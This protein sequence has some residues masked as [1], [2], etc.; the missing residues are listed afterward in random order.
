MSKVS[1]CIPTYNQTK[2]LKKCLQ[3]VCEQN[4]KDFEVIISDDSTTDEVKVYIDA[5][6]IIQPLFY[7]RN[8][9]SLGSPQN[10]NFALQ[11][12]KGEYIKILHHDDY[13]ATKDSLGKY[14]TILDQQPTTDFVFSATEII[15]LKEEKKQLHTCDHKDLE[16]L[17]SEPE[18]LFFKN[19]IGAPSAT[20]FRNY[21]PIQFDGRLKW[22]VDIDFYI[23]HL[24]RKN[25]IS[26]CNEALI[27][28]IHGAEEQITQNVIN[29]KAIQI[30]E[31]ILVLAK[32]IDQ[33]KLTRSFRR[34][35]DY[36]FY[37]YEIKSIDDIKKIVTIPSN[38]YIFLETILLEINKNRFLK[39]VRNRLL[40]SKL[41]T[42]Y[43]KIPKY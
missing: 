32:I 22:L 3:S 18:F 25:E 42:D 1:I 36:L 43:I 38:I 24:K 30:T 39:R 2:H 5:L 6:Q 15:L 35:I 14:V 41:N 28:T 34:Y 33:K 31:H 16:R 9:P 21:I 10:W 19:V 8:K 12:A 40:S 13:F 26:Y 17:R 27:C 7:F 20:M 23:Q 37:V 11:Q 4:Y 29:D